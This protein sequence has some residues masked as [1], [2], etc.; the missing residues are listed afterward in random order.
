MNTSN[1]IFSP[2]KSVLQRTVVLAL[3]AW[4]GLAYGP[5]LAQDHPD[6]EGVHSV[7]VEVNGLVCAFCAQGIRSTFNRQAATQEVLVSLEHRL[8]AV[9]FKPGQQISDDDITRLLT[10]AGYNVVSIQH[11]QASVAAIRASLQ[12]GH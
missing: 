2:F 5:A 11:G 10:D 1:R 7:R 12:D 3:V 8:V 6:Q 9:E 4:L